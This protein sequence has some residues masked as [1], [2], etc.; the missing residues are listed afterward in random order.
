MKYANED[1]LTRLEEFAIK[2]LALL[3]ERNSPVL[4]WK[5]TESMRQDFRNLA[6]EILA[7]KK[8]EL[9]RLN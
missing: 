2:K 3:L 7:R 1:E 6:K 4:P 9:M 5:I 8:A